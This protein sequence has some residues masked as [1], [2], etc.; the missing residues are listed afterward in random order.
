[1]KIYTD[2]HISK[3]LGSTTPNMVTFT[4][5]TT[6]YALTDG[7][8]LIFYGNPESFKDFNIS[9]INALIIL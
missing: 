8:F 4:I 5:I 6:K 2:G 3:R 1:M 7:A 9:V